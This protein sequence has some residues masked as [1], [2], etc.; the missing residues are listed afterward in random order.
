MQLTVTDSD[1]VVRRDGLRVAFN[2]HLEQHGRPILTREDF[3][4]A[5]T[6]LRPDVD[7]KQRM[8]S[9]RLQW[10]YVGIGLIGDAPSSSQDSQDSQDNLYLN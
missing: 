4:R 5:F 1:A 3:G 10:C 8:I 7:A 9:G 6:K 2:A